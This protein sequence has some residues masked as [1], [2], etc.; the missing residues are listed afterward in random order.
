[1]F[2]KICHES[3]PRHLIWGIG[4]FDQA[5]E[6]EGAA[7]GFGNTGLAHD[8]VVCLKH[9][10][11]KEYFMELKDKVF[12]WSKSGQTASVLPINLVSE[13]PY[14][15]LECGVDTLNNGYT[16]YGDNAGTRTLCKKCGGD[17]VMRRKYGLRTDS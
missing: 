7:I 1:M 12:K 13:Y 9:H 2:C 8:E 6:V 15:C 16:L 4:Q 17:S 11:V 3:I 5:L 14:F 10:G